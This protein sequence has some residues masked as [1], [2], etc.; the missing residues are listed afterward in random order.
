FTSGC[1]WMRPDQS[2]RDSTPPSARLPSAR[3]R[4]GL[5]R[6]PPG[7]LRLIR[8]G[9][10][11]T[12]TWSRNAATSLAANGKVAISIGLHVETRW[13]LWPNVKVEVGLGARSDAAHLRIRR[14][15]G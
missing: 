13:L 9:A 12:N 4:V 8:S 1:A 7:A 14:H 3:Q 6:S 11:C 5:L 15:Y 2:R 10:R